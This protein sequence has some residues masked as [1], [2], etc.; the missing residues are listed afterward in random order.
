MQPPEPFSFALECT[1]IV[2]HSGGICKANFYD[3]A[4]VL[5][6]ADELVRSGAVL[7]PFC[8]GSLKVHASYSRH[9]LDENGSIHNGWVAQGHCVIC[10]VY[11]ALIPDFIAPHKHYKAEVIEEVLAA[12]EEGNVIEDLGGCTADVSTMRR[13]VRQFRDRGAEAVGW[14]LSV[15]LTAYDR[16]IGSLELQSRGL[17]K[18]LARLL[19]KYSGPESG[20]IIGR[21]NIILTTQNCGFL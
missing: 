11:P 4:E 17:L 7:C 2:W 6:T 21:A 15:L 1:L 18:Q 19:S 13:W 8:H 5:H 16:H 20:R 14:L 12:Y 3:R 10:N 9:C